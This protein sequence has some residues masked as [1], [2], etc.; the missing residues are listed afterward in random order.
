[1]KNPVPEEVLANTLD[2]Y[3][4]YVRQGT[5]RRIDASQS[6]GRVVLKSDLIETLLC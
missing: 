1:M 3:S 6:P 2:D 5:T 4:Y